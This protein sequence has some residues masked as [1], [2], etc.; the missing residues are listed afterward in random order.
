MEPRE[1][2]LPISIQRNATAHHWHFRTPETADSPFDRV[3]TGRATAPAARPQR[4][5]TEPE[6]LPPVSGR[7][8]S[9]F[10]AGRWRSF[11]VR[12]TKSPFLV[13]GRKSFFIAGRRSFFVNSQGSFIVAGRW[14]FFVRGRRFFFVDAGELVGLRVGVYRQADP[15]G[16]APRIRPAPQVIGVQDEDR[17]L[18]VCGGIDDAVDVA[19]ADHGC[20]K[21]SLCD[22]IL[23][24]KSEELK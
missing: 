5:H 20:N 24:E 17:C 12:E 21:L 10:V 18:C 22:E 23:K 15:R 2:R 9:F 6:I 16:W 19:Y 4:L 1:R 3:G 13:R 14:S 8:R 11:F 7:H